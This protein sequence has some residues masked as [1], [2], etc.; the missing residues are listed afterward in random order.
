[1]VAVNW[2]PNGEDVYLRTYART[3]PDGR[4]ETWH[5]TV[6]RVVRGNLELVYGPDTDQWPARAHLDFRDLVTSMT[7][8]AILPAGRH[9]WASGV[10]GRQYLF[11]CWVAP[12]GSKVSDHFRFVFL[13]LMEGGGV[14]SNY[15]SD[16]TEQYGP[17]K[18]APEVHIVCDPNHPDYEQMLTDGLLSD[19]YSPDYTGRYYVEVE[20][21]REGWADALCR[22][23]D[24]AW[25]DDGPRILVFDV[26]RVR[27]AGSR[28]KTFGG[29][30][31]G[32]IPLARMLLGVAGVIKRLA[33]AVIL[34]DPLT[35]VQ[36][37]IPMD[38][39]SAMDID[40]EI[41]QCV[42]AGGVRRSA[43][44]SILPWDDPWIFHFIDC[45][46]DPAQHWTTN[47]SVA[48]GPEF[49]AA[50]E[51]ENTDRAKHARKVLHKI[52][53]GMLAN[54]EPG[55]WNQAASQ[56]GEVGE[57]IATNP[58]GEIA[59][60]PG[61]ACN[62]GHLNL[63][64]FV[65]NGDFDFDKASHAARLMTRFLIRATFGDI[66]D[67]ESRKVMDRNRRIGVGLF[68]VQA[69]FAKMG[70][71]YSEV[72][73]HPE[74]WE[75][76][77]RLRNVVRQEA[78]DYAFELRIPE[79][80]KTTTIAPTGT[81]AKLPG[82]TEG[83]HWIYSRYFLRRIRFSTVDPDQVAKLEEYKA[84]GYKVEPCIYAA[85]TAVVEIPTKDRLVEEV[86]AL[87]Y[88]AEIVES[89]DEVSLEQMLAIQAMFQTAWADNAVSF[90][91][92][93][94]AG[95]YTPE[96]ISEILQT[97]LPMLKG[98][99][100]MPEDSRPQAPYERI[101]RE[102]Y[103]QAIAKTVAESVDADCTNG[104]CPVR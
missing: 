100:I 102:Q 99:T 76:L 93:I 51:E 44:M 103:E 14:G 37:G 87:G 84:K 98:T 12:W 18:R 59:L 27:P 64:A 92:N 19:Y 101:S 57:V 1:M 97:Y 50:L 13:R 77:E 89:V 90:T 69:A 78:R 17:P 15:S 58:C 79:P 41:S 75:I 32:P 38:P 39:L 5:Q 26:S 80:V 83:I 86:E 35:E 34:G 28:L 46:R 30:A 94:P 104:I 47:I 4:K 96:Q 73:Q 60:Q 40:H 36:A 16:Y 61:E 88:S 85:N 11:N 53:K 52:A 33:P 24:S 23:L 62:L 10:R 21:S 22:L 49:F 56:I 29:Y 9:L 66:S 43:R 6:R 7:E 54:G 71:R 63:G 95:N 20:D 67:P 2:G 65:E 68:G 74:C 42:V 55:I 48:V 3:R 45:K 82:T 31:S 25:E 8:F 81:I 91:A 70:I 72:P